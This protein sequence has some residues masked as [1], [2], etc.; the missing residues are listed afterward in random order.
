MITKEE[1]FKLQYGDILIDQD[2]KRWKVNGSVQTWK[3]EANRHRI[4]VP[5]KHGLYTYD[6]ITEAD[7]DANDEC[8]LLTKE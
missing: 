7:F 1:A 5:F 2:G 4:R 3:R 8:H 6:Y